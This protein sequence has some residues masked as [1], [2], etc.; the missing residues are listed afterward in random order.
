MI[1]EFISKGKI[2]NI[3]LAN[4]EATFIH[5]EEEELYHIHPS[6]FIP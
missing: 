4:N 5:K 6:P 1:E 3:K 2:D